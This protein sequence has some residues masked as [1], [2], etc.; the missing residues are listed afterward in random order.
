MEK[1]FDVLGLV[2]SGAEWKPKG[3][4]SWA[5]TGEIVSVAD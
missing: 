5:D 3:D 4:P 1:G 2:S